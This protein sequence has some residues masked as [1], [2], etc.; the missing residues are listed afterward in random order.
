[1]LRTYLMATT[2]LASLAILPGCGT[3]RILDTERGGYVPARPG[4]F[5]LHRELS[6]RA[7]RTRVYLQ[8]GEVVPGVDEFRPHCQFEVNT[9]RET[10]QTVQPDN[11]VITGV[12]TRMDNIVATDH[13]QVAALETAA[14][15]VGIGVGFGRWGLFDGRETRRMQAYVF[16][17]HSDRQPDVRALTCGGAFDDPWLAD[18][19]TLQEIAAALGGYGRL[20]VE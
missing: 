7:G 18:L 17:L 2:L 3:P 12:S 13:I 1:M 15:G 5:E 16:R 8:G 6:V 9:L 14:V 4:V 19:P 11:F 20:V 10:P